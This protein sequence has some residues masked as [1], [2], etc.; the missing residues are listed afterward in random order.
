[1]LVTRQLGD[2]A[3]AQQT[4]STAGDAGVGV[5]GGNIEGEEGPAEKNEREE[6]SAGV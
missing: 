3:G 6:K 1:M 2:A 4:I 5:A